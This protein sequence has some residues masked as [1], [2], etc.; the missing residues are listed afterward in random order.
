MAIH[1]GA[2][3]LAVSL[4]LATISCSQSPP[5]HAPTPENSV[6]LPISQLRVLYPRLEPLPSTLT[7]AQQRD[8][9]MR[10]RQA[11]CQ[12]LELVAGILMNTGIVAEVPPK[13]QEITG[14]QLLELEEM[15][16]RACRDVDLTQLS[17]SE[18]REN[19]RTIEWLVK[20]HLAAMREVTEQRAQPRQ[21][22]ATGSFADFYAMH[23]ISI[24]E[25]R[26]A[27]SQL[28]ANPG[29]EAAQAMD[30][31]FTEALIPHARAE[32]RAL[33]PL[34]RSLDNP[35]LARVATA[36]EEEHRKIDDRIAAYENALRSAG[37]GQADVTRLY[38]LA[39]SARSLAE[40]HFA[41]EEQS[42]IKPLQQAV[43]PTRFGTVVQAIDEAFGNW[44]RQH[45]WR[46][47]S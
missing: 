18:L 10:L 35:T 43:T 47:S 17:L 26:A 31:F 22:E 44:L 46:R 23:D 9:L 30:R 40:L 14:L 6:D 4:L 15:E 45:G 12:D 21:V 25:M 39:D 33:W 41:K 5:T 7:D 37:Q 32:D 28:R 42:L 13:I 8:E 3:V 34:A 38:Q 29:M 24:R 11:L 20:V 19:V 36:L 27:L 2:A 16:T 1:R